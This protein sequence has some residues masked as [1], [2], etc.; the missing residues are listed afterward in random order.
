MRK[1]SSILPP[2]KNRAHSVVAKKGLFS[3][4]PVCLLHWGPYRIE[5]LMRLGKLPYIIPI[6]FGLCCNAAA[7]TT[8]EI[9]FVSRDAAQHTIARALKSLPNVS[10]GRKPCAPATAKEFA[11]PPITPE[12]ARAAIIAG[13]KSARLRWCGL[14]WKDRAYSV[15]RLHYQA[16]GIYEARTLA[17]LSQIHDIRF[18]EDYL[19]LQAL[20]TCSGK[21]RVSLD[22]ENPV[23]K[24]DPWQRIANN[25]LLDYSVAEMLEL[26]LKEIHK[27]RCGE[28]LCNPAT[29]E[30]MAEPPL[31][32]PQARQA[33]RIGLF[34]GAA[35][36]CSLDW[37]RSIFYPFITHEKNSQKMT[38]RQLTMISMLH[39]TM[40]N[41]IVKKYRE[42]ETSC[43]D[44]MRENL[45]RE[46]TSG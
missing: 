8:E 34:S 40:H 29:K 30:E 45:Q 3:I 37:K 1:S 36:F 2:N 46:L 41:Y 26:V 42:H 39:G 44:T 20:K 12:Q 23:I 33:M 4:L 17:L 10:C 35:D 5:K 22:Q 38:P 6:F 15:L 28:E 24:L 9:P 25:S 7:Q 32:I 13:A 14:S 31:S 21:R 18:H 11:D 16:Q 43:S 19:G 27:S